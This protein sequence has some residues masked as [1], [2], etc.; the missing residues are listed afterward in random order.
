MLET[1]RTISITCFFR[2]KLQRGLLENCRINSPNGNITEQSDNPL[3]VSVHYHLKYTT[4]K[5]KSKIR[6]IYS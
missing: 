3:K 2:H 5:D 1:T 4:K 6:G